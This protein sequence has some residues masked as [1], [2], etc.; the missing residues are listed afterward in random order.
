MK[1]ENEFTVSV[2]VEQA[3]NVLLDLERVTPCLPGAALTAQVGDEYEGTMTVKLGPATAKY[4]GTV[5]IEEADEQNRRAVIKASGKDARGQGTAAATIV[6]TL[7]DE[8]GGSTRVRVETDMRLTGRV[9]QFG[10]GIQQDVA[11]K[12]LSRF[13][14]CLEQEI[15][16]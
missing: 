7:H 13:A 15:I 5:K 6:S 14:E 16:R 3:W 12:I 8:G 1:L 11:N 9:A 2:P 10:R 4:N